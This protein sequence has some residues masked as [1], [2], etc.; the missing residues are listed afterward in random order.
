VEEAGVRCPRCGDGS[1]AGPHATRYR[2][3]VKDLFTGEVFTDLPILRVRF[4][5]GSTASL[6]PAD[7]WRGRSTL[8]TVVE[9]VIR[10]VDEGIAAALEWSGIASRDGEEVSERTLRRWRDEV[11]RGRLV[12]SALAV[13]GP[14]VDFSWSGSGDEADQLALLLSLL[15]LPVLLAF[16]AETG[17]SVLDRP[18]RPTPRSRSAARPVAGRLAPAPPHDP[19]SSLRARG[20]WLPQNR[21][22]PPRR[23]PKGGSRS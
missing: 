5:E 2:K 22:G 10:A 21:R 23:S 4:C 18:P 1:C 19:P 15:T 11:V 9:T 16:R 3:R 8:T 12:G 14:Q 7:L 20:L 17:H 13:L 6:M